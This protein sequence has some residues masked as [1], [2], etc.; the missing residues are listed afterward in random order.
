MEFR[1]AVIHGRDAGVVRERARELA[2]SVTE[3]PDNPFD[4]A[5]V[6]E[7]DLERDPL[8]LIDELCAVSM[9]GGR[10]LVRLRLIEERGATARMVAEGMDEHLAGRCNPQA[11]LIVEAPALAKD[12]S[13]RKVAERAGGCA[14]IPCYEDE[15]GEVK[16][17][18]R[19]ALAA[20]GLSLSGEALDLFVGRLPHDRGVA[21]AEIERL[22]LYL[23]PGGGLPA[24]V[25][26]LEAFLGVEPEASLAQ[27]ADDAFGGR[28]DRAR[29]GFRRAALELEAGPPAVRAMGQHLLRLRRTLVLRDRGSE[30]PA[31]ARSA[32]V[33][34]K[35]E[36]EFLRQARA[37]DL[38]SLDA[39]Q[40]DIL[41]A[42]RNC[43]RAGAPAEFVAERLALSIAA[44]AQRLGL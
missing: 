30:L 2:S 3:H 5:V 43:K 42:D 40:A 16:T 25:A 29:T 8:R 36:R 27:A 12:S 28:L 9:M 24:G 41:A 13:L 18:V 19:K 11:F 20:E 21:R 39:V 22:A 44:H 32:G 23:G 38:P 14:L 10:R 1:A 17:L 7:T 37:W 35:N 15:P 26:E 33:F 31:A 34:W 6:T 4:V